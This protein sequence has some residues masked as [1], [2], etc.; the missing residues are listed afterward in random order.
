VVLSIALEA[1]VTILLN[2]PRPSLLRS[3]KMNALGVAVYP[4]LDP[5]D[6]HSYKGE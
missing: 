1:F 2:G 6:T 5:K 4:P 3:E